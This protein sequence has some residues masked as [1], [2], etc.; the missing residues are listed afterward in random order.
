M[1]L[2]RLE[3]RKSTIV[4]I[5]RLEVKITLNNS[6]RHFQY[7]TESLLTK[8]IRVEREL[9]FRN[10]SYLLSKVSSHYV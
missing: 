4:D 8:H 5:R 1:Q 9:V 10:M 2:W 6:A 7:F 3:G